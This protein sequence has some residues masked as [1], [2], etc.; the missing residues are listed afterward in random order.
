MTFGELGVYAGGERYVLNVVAAVQLAGGSSIRQAMVAYGQGASVRIDTGGSELHVLQTDWPSASHLD[1]FSSRFSSRLWSIAA[2]FDL[3]HVYQP[4]NISGE[5]ALIVAAQL[6]K[7]IVATDLGGALLL[8]AAQDHPISLAHR[9]IAISRYAATF[10]GSLPCPIDTVIGPVGDQFLDAP[11]SSGPRAGVLFV[12]RIMPHKG[13]DRILRHAPDGLEI[14][15]AGTV[16]DRDYYQYLQG[17]VGAKHVQFILKPSED[18]LLELY[19]Q[20]AACVVPS[21]VVDYRGKVIPNS[22]L[23]GLTT[24]EALAQGTPVA[25]ATTTSLPELVEGA[26]MARVFSND[27]ELRVVLEDVAAGRWPKVGC[28]GAARA[29]AARRF[30]SRAVGEALI[31]SYRQAAVGAASKR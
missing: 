3:V 1:Y 24:M 15:I 18:R 28:D 9:V 30:S 21:V 2:D 8:G 11:L 16:V 17:L 4:F 12:G 5:A 26:S 20:A 25:V 22:E 19:S 7:T 27:A 29:Y 6:G 23:M 10:I 31:E 13:I 14:T